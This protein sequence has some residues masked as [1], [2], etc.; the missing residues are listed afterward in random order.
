V[1]NFLPKALDRIPQKE[2]MSPK[3]TQPLDFI[4]QPEISSLTS[5][6]FIGASWRLGREIDK[7]QTLPY[8]TN[9]RLELLDLTRA[10]ANWPAPW[11][12]GG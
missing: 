11:P 6:I 9:L 3:K 4:S 1:N 12:G 8:Q 10:D 5:G 2:G 7:W